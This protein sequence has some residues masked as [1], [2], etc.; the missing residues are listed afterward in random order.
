MAARTGDLVIIRLLLSSGARLDLEDKE[1]DSTPL[2]WA[3]FHQ[4]KRAF[5]FLKAHGAV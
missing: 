5:D 3:A 4:R 1:H 2:G